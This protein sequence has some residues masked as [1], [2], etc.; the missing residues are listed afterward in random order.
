MISYSS[1]IETIHPSIL[2]SFREIA[3]Y[4]SKF[5][6]FDLPHLHFAPPLGVTPFEFRKDFWQQK[7]R[8][9]G[10]SRGILCV[11]LHL[12][13][14]ADHRLVTGTDTQT[15]RHM[16]IVHIVLAYC[17]KAKTTPTKSS[18][19]LSRIFLL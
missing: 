6:K 13:I 19:I 4:L 5:A 15:D 17:R 1:L 16:A 9:P 2:Y 11:I 18:R 8:V 12:T 7:T 3:S 10:L 14:L